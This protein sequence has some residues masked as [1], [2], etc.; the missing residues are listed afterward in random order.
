MYDQLGELYSK[1]L[2]YDHIKAREYFSKAISL[3]EETSSELEWGDWSFQLKLRIHD[4]YNLHLEYAE[5]LKLSLELFRDSIQLYRE[6]GNLELLIDQLLYF[7]NLEQ[8]EGNN[9]RS[10]LYLQLAYSTL[11]KLD[12]KEI[13][14]NIYWALDTLSF[15]LLPTFNDCKDTNRFISFFEK[16]QSLQKKKQITE[17][18]TYQSETSINSILTAKL[19]CSENS[20]EQ[21]RFANQILINIETQINNNI[22]LYY[23]NLSD[24]Y[25]INGI[26][27]LNKLSALYDISTFISKNDYLRVLRLIQDFFI[28]THNLKTLMISL[29]QQS[30]I[31]QY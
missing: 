12:N 15:K 5:A 17:E 23:K 19:Y 29:W 30:I 31:F 16:I 10:D 4:S 7:G 1:N 11:E 18:N 25:F 8:A 20:K 3:I 22:N 21:E 27:Y 13:G 28:Y 9:S 26:Y 14:A 6:S 24:D 2:L